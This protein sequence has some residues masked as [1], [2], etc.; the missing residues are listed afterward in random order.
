MKSLSKCFS[1]YKKS[2]KGVTSVFGTLLF[3]I[4][5]IA[6]AAILFIAL[7]QYNSII[8]QSTGREGERA[9]ERIVFSNVTL[10]GNS[11]VGVNITN[12]GSE[13]VQIR[14]FY[15]N[16]IFICD[17][18][19]PST[20]AD[21]A[22]LEGQETRII[23]IQSIPFN[24]NDRLTV[25]T[26]RGVKSVQLVANL[27]PGEISFQTSD[28]N[29]GPLRLNFTQFFYQTTDKNGNPTGTWM[30]GA[31]IPSS[32][33]YCAWN[34]TVTNIDT[35]AITIN[36]YSSLDLVSNGG[37]AQIPWYLK[38]TSQT[39]SA[40]QT[41]NIIFVWD[42]PQSNS[43]QKFSSFTT[44]KVFMT[45]YGSFSDGLPYGQTIPFEAIRIQ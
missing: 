42:G 9:Q 32:V 37:G 12:I 23:N 10:S 28:T 15:R 14:G 41:V 17:P 43:G 5:A 35:R 36:R 45:F 3:M 39:I 19:D 22:Y 21:G 27:F 4:V 11:L 44:A 1:K 8:Q 6:V 2:N 34:I 38:N 26:S 30:P 33:T 7:F 31:V 13:Q 25:A 16:N 29:Y 18:S 40:N 24:S 20:N